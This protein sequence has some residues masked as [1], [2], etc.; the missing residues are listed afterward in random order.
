MQVLVYLRKLKLGLDISQSI[1]LK[2]DLSEGSIGLWGLSIKHDLL[3]WV[4]GIGNIIPLDLSLQYGLTNLN[5]NFQIESQG[6][7]QSVNLKQML[8][9]LT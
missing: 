4:P 1:L 8:V 3:Q 5:T 2:K 9:L 7:K 6:V